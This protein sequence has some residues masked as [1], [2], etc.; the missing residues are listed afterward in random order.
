MSRKP[1]VA[2][3]RRFSCSENLFLP[4]QKS[5]KHSA[6]SYKSRRKVFWKGKDVTPAPLTDS[7][8]QIGCTIDEV[9]F[10]KEGLEDE[11]TDLLDHKSSIDWIDEFISKT[12]NGSDEIQHL[13]KKMPRQELS[14]YQTKSNISKNESG[15]TTIAESKDLTMHPTTNH[16]TQREHKSEIENG[17]E[18]EFSIVLNETKTMNILS[19]SG[20]SFASDDPSY[21][22]VKDRNKMYDDK[23]KNM[24][25]GY[26]MRS[27][28]RY[29]QTYHLEKKVFKTMIFFILNS[30]NHRKYLRYA[31]N[32]NTFFSIF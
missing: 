1:S 10:L 15:N 13:Y 3:S 16:E 17:N 19:L 2:A 32:S 23:C 20:A 27:G 31:T 22:I 6:N 8:K 5:T 30:N 29:A 25:Q 12:K 4:N 7:E 9:G 28:C 18:P 11:N 24:R 14:R 26:G 21:L